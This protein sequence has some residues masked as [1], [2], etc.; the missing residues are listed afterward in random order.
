MSE[1]LAGFRS[2]GIGGNGGTASLAVSALRSPTQSMHL[3]LPE[4]RPSSGG[5]G[6]EWSVIG[7]IWIEKPLHV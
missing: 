6:R 1:N 5:V 7:S 3:E 2:R 4:D